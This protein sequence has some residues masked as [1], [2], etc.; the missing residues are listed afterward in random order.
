MKLLKKLAAIFDYTNL[1]L[2]V[3]GVVL[4]LFTMFSVLINVTMRDFLD[5]AQHWVFEV[6]E[7]CLVWI[8][9]LG[10]AWLLRKEGH[11]KMEFVL[12]RLSPK[13]QALLNFSTSILAGI[14]CLAIARYG[15]EVTWSH[16][17]R[18]IVQTLAI[19]IP[20]GLY[21]VIIAFGSFLLFIQ[22]IRRAYGY[23]Q[24]WKALRSEQN[25]P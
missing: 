17:E 4:I 10:A 24:S 3:L 19:R 6:A 9:F 7:V 13:V 23:L 20:S 16:F 18:G 21:L 5:H 1:I 15:A 2:A 11:V 8:T 22:F 25:E 12:N 14:A